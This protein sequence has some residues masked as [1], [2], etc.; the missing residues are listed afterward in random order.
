LFSENTVMSNCLSCGHERHTNELKCSQCGNYYSKIYQ[1]LDEEEA[2]EE[3]NSFRSQCLRIFRS[4]DVKQALMFELKQF[5]ARVSRQGLFALFV[6][7]AF[8]FALM[9]TV[10]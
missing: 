10:L 3:E 7:I 2:R 6:V 8:I 9:V 5:I 4:G 1:L